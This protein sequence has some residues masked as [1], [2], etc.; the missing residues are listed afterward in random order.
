MYKL[1]LIGHPVQHSKSPEIHQYFLNVI[2]ANGK[3]ELFDV[4]EEDL[5]YFL[6]ELKHSDMNGVNVTIPYKEKVIPYLDEIDE[7]AQM[8]KAVN[9]IKR[10]GNKLIGYNTDGEGFIDSLRYTY[11][12]F[13]KDIKDKTVLIL[14]AGGAAKGIYFSLKKLNPKRIDIANRTKRKAENIVSENNHLVLALE[15]AEEK[16]YE[17]DLVIQ[18]TN[19]GMEPDKDNQVI[20]L[21]HL[22]RGAIVSDIV[23]KPKMTKFLLNGKQQGARLLF[24]ESMLWYQAAKSFKIWTDQSVEKHLKID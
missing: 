23:Y 1:G 19:V 6:N 21:T 2:N 12:K 15:E 8:L 22:N 17:Y 4:M 20:K 24:G 18:T 10:K 5:E 9:T 7:H 13:V 16:L 11:P 3:Y 14:G